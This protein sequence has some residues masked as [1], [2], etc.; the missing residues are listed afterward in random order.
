MATPVAAV[1]T[2][3]MPGTVCTAGIDMLMAITLVGKV[4]TSAW[5]PN[6]KNAFNVSKGESVTLSML[7]DPTPIVR[8]GV[9]D[10]SQ[11]VFDSIA[12][13]TVCAEDFKLSFENGVTAHLSAPPV[14]LLGVTGGFFFSLAK[15]RPV[16]DA[17]WLSQDAYLPGA[18][19]KG[20]EETEGIPLKFYGQLAKGQFRPSKFMGTFSIVYDRN[21]I[22]DLDIT[23]AVGT[24]TRKGVVK[25]TMEITRDFATNVALTAHFESLTITPPGSALSSA[26]R[27][28][29]RS[30]SKASHP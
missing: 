28:A 20:V 19:G 10:P 13:Y 1:P 2:G 12:P 18:I 17:A 26:I 27:T 4:T 23:N 24:Y 14:D 11:T 3:P 7:V 21:T 29:A 16:M 30:E 5:Q 9:S 25:A 8:M 15:S 6:S 22:P